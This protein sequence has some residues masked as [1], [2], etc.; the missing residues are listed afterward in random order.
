MKPNFE[1]L[2]DYVTVYRRITVVDLLI[3][4]LT[5]EYQ[6]LLCLSNEYSSAGQL[7][8]ALSLSFYGSQIIGL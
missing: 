4:L 6:Y 3:G 2:I 1:L 5:T 7:L 8:S